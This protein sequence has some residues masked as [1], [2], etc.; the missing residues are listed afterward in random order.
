MARPTTRGPAGRRRARCGCGRCA[1]ASIIA[2]RVSRAKTASCGSA[3]AITGRSEEAERAVAPAAGRAATPAARRRPASAPAP[4][5]KLGIVM[6]I[7]ASAIT[8]TSTSRSGAAPPGA[9]RDAAA[10]R[11]RQGQRTQLER[12]GQALPDQLQRRYSR[13]R[14]SSARNRRARHCRDRADIA[15]TAAGRAGRPAIMFARICGGSGRSRLNG[16]PGANR[17]RKND[18]VTTMNRVGTALASRRRMKRSMGDSDGSCIAEGEGR[19]VGWRT[20][21]CRSSARPSGTL[22]EDTRR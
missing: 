19:G 8:A 12:I 10:E 6:P 15:A 4:T 20:A 5:T 7:V 13:G 2:P 3:S 18:R 22:P 9:G 11:D 1:S 14:R 16:P 21:R 17:M